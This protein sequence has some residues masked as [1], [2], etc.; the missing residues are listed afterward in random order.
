LKE[1]LE[2]LKTV[3]EELEQQKDAYNAEYARFIEQHKELT[4]KIAVSKGKEFDLVTTIKAE[5][6]EE[7]K[8]TGNKAH[9]GGVAIRLMSVIE[10]D[11]EEA[12]RWAEEHKLAL[13]LDKKKFEKFA[14]IED[15]SFVG[16][17]EVAQATIPVKL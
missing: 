8:K 4:A 11:Y 14:K 7:Y 5:A 9:E 10:Y 16:M 17:S 2:E 3:R 12:L 13:I 6:V 1:Q 15:M